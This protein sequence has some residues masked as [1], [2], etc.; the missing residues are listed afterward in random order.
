MLKRINVYPRISFYKTSE[1]EWERRRLFSLSTFLS[2]T[3]F[4]VLAEGCD[5]KLDNQ[6]VD[7]S[8]LVR[9]KAKFFFFSIFFF[10]LLLF[11]IHYHYSTGS[12]G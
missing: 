6:K 9:T 8:N 4:S 12:S 7:G 2:V 3:S 5:R 10:F 1:R 11:S